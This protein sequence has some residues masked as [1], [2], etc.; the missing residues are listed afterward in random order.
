MPNYFLRP[1]SA[2]KRAQEFID[3]GKEASAL[4]A[5]YEV[6]KSR[7]HRTWQKVH[8]PIM[9]L[10][11]KLCVDLKK[12]H[13]AKE[14]L[15]Q[16]RNICQQ[17]NIASL[18][19]VV[20][21]YLELAESKT[22]QAR[23]SSAQA[24]IEIDD[25]DQVQTPESLLMSAVSSE[26]NQERSDR[27]MLTPWVKFLW[28]S[29]R[30]CLEL[31]RNNSRVERLY[32]DIAQSAFQFCLK[33]SRKTEFRKLCDNLRSHL[34]LIHRYQSNVTAVNL[35]SSETQQMHLETRLTQLDIAIKMELWLEAYKATEDIHTMMCLSKKSTKPQ[36][37]ATY[38]QRLALVF[39]K[40]GNGLFHASALF[41]H[42]TLVKDLKKTITQD[43]LRKLAARVILATLSTPL[44]P[45][46]IEI[47]NLVET[48]ESIIEKN[49]RTL[50]NLLGL[51]SP[52]TR[53]G[54]V[55][56]LM[57]LGVVSLAPPEFQRLYALLESEFDPLNLCA[58]V[59]E[60]FDFIKEWSKEFV[61]D[62]DGSD[63][64]TVYL[65][66]LKSMMVCRLLREIAQVYESISIKRVLELCPMVDSF[67]LEAAVVDAVRR[68]SLQVRIDHKRQALHFGSEL[69]ISQREETIEGPHLQAM[70]SDLIRTQLEKLYQV[71]HQSVNI[72][73]PEK[74]AQERAQLRKEIYKVYLM[75]SKKEH[76]KILERQSRI[77]KRK[78]DLENKSLAREEEERR[79]EE[80]R[81]Q[82]LKE[83]EAARLA[84]EAQ[85]R[86]M[87]RRQ[88]EEDERRRKL[89]LEKIEQ[90]KKTE[91]GAK[92][93]EGM[94]DHVLE[95]MNT[96]EIQQIQLD[97]WTKERKELQLR[98]QK[99][100]RLVDHMERA[101]RLEEIPLL[102]K[103]FLRQEEERRKRWDEMEK[104]R[105]E[106]AIQERQIAMEHKNRL[107]RMIE[108]KENFIKK[109]QAERYEEYKK[110][111]E[112]FDKMWNEEKAR[113][114]KQRREE[115]KEE[116]REEWRREK[117]EKA[118]LAEEAERKQREDEARAAR[119]AAEEKRRQREKELL[120]KREAERER[121]LAAIREKE[122][123]SKREPIDMWRNRGSTNDDTNNNFGSRGRVQRDDGPP[124]RKSMGFGSSSNTAPSNERW[125]RAP[126]AS[127]DRDN[128]DSGDRIKNP[129]QQ[130][131]SRAAGSGSASSNDNNWR[132]K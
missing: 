37:M 42:F 104:E 16:Y 3:V 115:R 123:S 48:D 6:I 23:D 35:Q 124:T 46:R 4:D 103:E 106:K 52:P 11:L 5:L 118:R 130:F 51:A 30:Q 27:V 116:R 101:K 70:P 25:L 15:F 21:D 40:A 26:G 75:V 83:A 7:K 73:Q 74:I 45:N 10:Y 72:I 99:Q 125:E 100:E 111:K 57:R 32:H 29:Y 68:N 33:Y 61:I 66:G 94:E 93:I 58:G 86:E 107:S 22:K 41:K 39:L 127:S 36:L 113:R 78:E 77:E 108:D 55:K 31:L 59:S 102:E 98:L 62:K 129:R 81:Q 95:K 120:D 67:E 96:E 14:G 17:V 63:E 38:Y 131:P 43:E 69:T 49:P 117:E 112:A 8:E 60:C 34:Q 20:K 13:V 56:D 1:E 122:R 88:R 76:R 24:V 114:L 97:H 128:Q 44:P 80:K 9:T 54:L 119:E 64:L 109:L 79:E 126:Q 105:V 82:K 19:Q 12:S 65:G 92:I 121:D 84:K 47:D 91:F 53:Q 110:K 85:E 28:E 89:M 90:L 18:E 71:L 132:K 2:L 87:I 50:A